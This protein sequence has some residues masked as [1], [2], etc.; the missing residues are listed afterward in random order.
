[1]MLGRK[2]VFLGIHFGGVKKRLSIYHAI[3]PLE[4]SS[5][6]KPKTRRSRKQLEEGLI[7][8]DATLLIKSEILLYPNVC[9]TSAYPKI[10]SPPK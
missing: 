1:M 10:T 8:E 3:L 2:M 6:P 9:W 4:T 7:Q 5:F